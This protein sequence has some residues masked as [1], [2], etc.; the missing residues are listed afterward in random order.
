MKAGGRLFLSCGIFFG[1][2]DVVYWYASKDPAGTVFLAPQSGSPC[3]P[4]FYMLFTGRLGD[5][6][7]NETRRDWL[8]RTRRA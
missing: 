5:P 7:I 4:G 1:G 8:T 2:S 6:S 3:S